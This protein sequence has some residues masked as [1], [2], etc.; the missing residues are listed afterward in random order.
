MATLSTLDHI[1]FRHIII[2]DALNLR[3]MFF[4]INIIVIFIL[5]L[6][7]ENNHD[8]CLDLIW[9][10]NVLDLGYGVV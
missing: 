4:L 6:K 1:N 8:V 9:V 7:Y 10:V 2:D 5:S 3:T